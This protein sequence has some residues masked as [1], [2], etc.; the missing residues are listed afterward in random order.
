MSIFKSK[1][2]KEASNKIKKLEDKIE[3]LTKEK[4]ELYDKVETLKVDKK[5]SEE[6]IKHMIKKKE[7]MLDIKFQKKELETEKKKAEDIANVKDEYRDKLE[8]RLEIEVSNMKDM[9]GEILKR[10]PNVNYK[11]NGGRDDK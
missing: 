4:L 6:D 7:E 11:I 9:Y 5:T 3:S 10:L 8:K 1:T 2:E